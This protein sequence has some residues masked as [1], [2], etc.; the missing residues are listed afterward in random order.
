V[1]W[2]RKKNNK[3]NQKWTPTIERKVARGL[4][5]ALRD[6]GILEGANRKQ[7]APVHIPLEA[8][9][10]IAFELNQQGLSGHTL[11]NNLDWRLFLLYEANVERLMMQC[12]QRGWLRF[13]A[14]GAIYRTEFP[15]TSFEGYSH[16]VLNR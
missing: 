16:D 13:D 10:L 9:T 14:A 1:I 4:L 6:F 3:L 2:L 8:F 12:Q 5:A 11:V 7:I 15:E